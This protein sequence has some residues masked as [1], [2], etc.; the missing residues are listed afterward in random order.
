MSKFTTDRHLEA[1]FADEIRRI[2]ADSFIKQ[3]VTADLSEATDFAIFTVKPFKVAVRLRRY[4]YFHAF[5]DEFTLRWSRPSGVPTEIHKIRQK[6]VN[7]FLYGFL[8]KPETHIIHY[9][10]FDL[11][12]FTDPVP[13]E[14]RKNDPPDSELAIYRIDQF[15]KEFTV[16]FHDETQL[17]R[18]LSDW[19]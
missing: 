9:R 12:R 15:P 7:Y 3:D 1:Q 19:L 5:K 4:D 16:I 6:L 10:I 2:L 18:S 14:I 11:A 8:D 13:N 17:S